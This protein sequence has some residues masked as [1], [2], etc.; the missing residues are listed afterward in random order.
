MLNDQC[1]SIK[2]FALDVLKEE[3]EKI[4]KTQG[5]N[6]QEIRDV[7]E[8]ADRLTPITSHILA[9]VDKENCIEDLDTTLK[10]FVGEFK[11]RRHV[12]EY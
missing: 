6:E 9:R 10:L 4:C 11:C 8:I 2:Q 3:R 12:G 5:V 1:V 7:I